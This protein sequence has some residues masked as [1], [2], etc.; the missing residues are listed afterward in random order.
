MD[1]PEG[2]TAP[3]EL[4]PDGDLVNSSLP[5]WIDFAN[6]LLIFCAGTLA[7]AAGVG[8]GAVYTVLYIILFGLV[9]EAIPLSKVAVF[10]TS[11]AFFVSHIM[12]PVPKC[13]KHA[14]RF[15]YD[16]VMIMEP[17]T[18]LGT[19][20]GVL[21]SRV[22][23]YWLI[24]TMMAVLLSFS[25]SKT[26][27][28]GSKIRSKETP[29]L[30]YETEEDTLL[31]NDS[32]DSDDSLTEDESIWR[33]DWIGW[34]CFLSVFICFA[35]VF[36]TSLLESDL[37]S[38]KIECGTWQFWML[39]GV[40][41]LVCA[42][43]TAWNVNYLVRSSYR[44]QQSRE[45]VILWDMEVGFKY[46]SLCFVAGLLSALCGVGGSTIKG[47]ILLQMGIHPTLSKATS[48]LMLLS[49]VSASAFQ[50]YLEGAVPPEY[51]IQF[52]TIA[53]LAALCGKF[54][55]DVYVERY[56]GRQSTIVFLLAWYIVIAAVL[57]SIIGVVI[58]LGQFRPTIDY[59]QLW[60]RSICDAIPPDY[61]ALKL[62]TEL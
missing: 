32:F 44:L 59:Q 2:T 49:T 28:K 4:M 10:G 38:L 20:I 27:A 54:A 3:A 41:I 15:A 53:I 55:I 57:M 8:G 33:F 45:C 51:A 23:P 62:L 43:V 39:V 11:L 42:S 34:R 35:T 40:N 13:T 9:Y 14:N 48:Q 26:F 12:N 56:G 60:F 21:A 7:A 50:F 16:A 30:G 52:F 47:P 25:A 61:G 31:L 19:V 1:F 24:T 22:F 17:T 18:L 6:C 37:G 46:S 29:K 58:I 36:T 5:M